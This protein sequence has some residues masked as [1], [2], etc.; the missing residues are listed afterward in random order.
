MT[1]GFLSV[2]FPASISVGKGI[3]DR[4]T[5]GDLKKI[6]GRFGRIIE[7][8]IMESSENPNAPKFSAIVT[9]RV[10]EAAKRAAMA[11]DELELRG[12]AM[13][14]WVLGL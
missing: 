10:L 9:F 8:K 6:F 2:D 3:D 4:T 7:I 1:K 13:D 12:I 5:T 11:M 14:V